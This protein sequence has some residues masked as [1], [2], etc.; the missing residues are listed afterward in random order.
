[1]NEN[2]FITKDQVE[3]LIAAAKI[4]ENV[5]IVFLLVCAIF[6]FLMQMGF[7]ML[8]AGTVRSKNS[9]N[10]LLKNLLDTYV[11]A[12]VYYLIGYGLA[13]NAQGGI[14]G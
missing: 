5:D 6:I 12:I 13:N 8:E 10:I 14:I 1:M 3:S 9:S 2:Y 11:G 4:D 7:A